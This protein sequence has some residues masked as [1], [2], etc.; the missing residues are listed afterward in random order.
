VEIA[1]GAETLSSVEKALSLEWLIAD[2]T[3][4]YASS[5]V[6]G[7][8]TRRYHG[9]LVAA[10]RPPTDRTVLLSTVEEEVSIREGVHN[11]STNEYP[12]VFHPRGHRYLVGFRLRPFPQWTYDLGGTL[13][14]KEVMMLRGRRAVCIRYRLAGLDGK[15]RLKVVPMLACRGMHELAGP[16]AAYEVHRAEGSR[17][18]KLHGGTRRLEA[19]LHAS[20]GSYQEE[21]L[22][23]SRMTYRREGERGF[24]AEEELFSPGSFVVTLRPQREFTITASAGTLE[25]VDPKAER[26]RETK[27]VSVY[28]EDFAPHSQLEHELALAADAFLVRGAGRDT[29][30][31]AGYPWF[32][33]WGRDALIS[34]EGL[35]L[36][37]GRLDEAGQVLTGFAN[38]IVDGIVPNYLAADPAYDAFN[39]IDAG[40]W[41][42][43]ATARY[44][45]YGGNEQLARERLWP[46]VCDLLDS[47]TAGTRSDIRADGD[48][49]LRGGSPETQ[50]TWMDAKVHGRAV[51]PRYGK[52]V[53]VNALWYNALCVGAELSQRFAGSPEGYGSRSEKVRRAFEEVFWCDECGCLYDYVA[54]DIVDSRLRPNQILAVSL[55]HSVL[56]KAKWESVLEVVSEHLYTPYGLRTLAPS[57]LDYRGRY[58]GPEEARDEAYHQGTVWA[59]LLGPFYETYLKVHDHSRHARRKVGEALSVWEGHLREAGL[60][61]VSEVFNGDSPHLAGGCIAQAWSVAELLRISRMVSE[62]DGGTKALG[63]RRKWSR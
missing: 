42:V 37:T 40:L 5:T 45:A 8:N 22:R 48:G 12:G 19:H 24:D 28:L 4:S 62:T 17:A 25:G 38:R 50:L 43:H 2:G 29:N 60:G 27:R 9:L 6:I 18:V 1:F 20:D 59:W 31:I 39:S 23:F 26:D 41:F 47:Y 21:P 30:I 55:P 63:S 11:L 51:T 10:Q 3:G 58:E 7:C 57:E 32:E 61:Q 52:A 16:G 54:G 56:E 53:E 46:K 14:R 33:V 13:L 35:A 15:V 34:L 49:L 44:L 36:V